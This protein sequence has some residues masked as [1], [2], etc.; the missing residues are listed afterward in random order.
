[1]HAV[2]A[3][4]LAI[5]PN[6]AAIQNDEAYIRLLLLPAEGE[7]T[8]QESAAIEQLAGKLIEREPASM[9]HRTLLALARLRQGRNDDALSVYSGLQ[10]T[11]DALTGS[12]L[13][14]HAAILTATAHTEDAKT[15]AARIIPEQILPE[16][17]NLIKDFAEPR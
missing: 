4:M 2:L 9:P 5:W 6:D 1:L 3:E 13:A 12:A 15:E 16:E 10:L 14:V 17:E 8:K 11:P 7:N